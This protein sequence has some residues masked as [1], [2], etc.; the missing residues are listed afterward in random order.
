MNGCFGKYIDVDLS[1]EKVDDYPI[2]ESWYE[3]HLGGRGI[4]T[5]ILVEELEGG[6]DPLGPDNIMVFATGPYQGTGAPGGGKHAIFGRSPKNNTINESYAGGYFGHAL[7]RSG[8]D[9][10]VIR[11]AAKTPQCLVIQN[12]K[13][14]IVDADDLWG[15]DT[16]EVEEKIKA[17]YKNVSVSSIG[18]AGENLVQSACIINDRC[19]SLGRSGWGAVM[20]SKK[21]KAIAC[22]GN[23][24]KPVYDAESLKKDIRQY[25]KYIKSREDRTF[26]GETGTINHVKLYSDLGTLPTKNF[27][28]ACYDD[29]VKIADVGL[30]P[31][32]VRRGTC[33]GCPIACKRVV[34]TE[35]MGRPVMERYGGPEYE[36]SVAF[37]SLCLN[38][39]IHAVCLANQLCNQYGLDTI[40]TGC[41]IAFVM[42]A[43]DKGLLSEAQGAK[44]G[45]AERVI[46]LVDL[47]AKREGIG[48]SLAKGLAHF[49]KEIGGEAFAMHIKGQEVPMHEPRGKV[50][51]A[52]SYA[53]S[54]RGA[55][56]VDGMHDHLFVIPDTMPLWGVTEPVDVF[57]WERKPEVDKLAGDIMS[58]T[59]S[60]IGCLFLNLPLAHPEQFEY[61]RRILRDI[62][63]MDL[64]P[65]AVALIGERNVVIRKIMTAW[66]GYTRADDDLPARFK[67]PLPGGPA[68][69]RP[70]IHEEFHAAVDKWYRLRGYDAY[71]PT[72]EKLA[73]LGLKE[74]QGLIRRNR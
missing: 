29:A 18:I 62:T 50:G 48:D 32:L 30:A 51:L 21:L 65:K 64:D 46:E 22:A 63:G 26:F 37:G 61:D 2:P 17:R 6:E 52:I 8:F 74:L 33:A 3:R 55:N 47:I 58:F 44:W 38:N 24:D 19:S 4:A 1:R 35:F 34:K 16:G 60:M 42:E 12:G 71:G 69:G 49:A 45:D 41:M 31:I 59:D 68:A 28:E 54:P 43:T 57:T 5:R 10:I 36:T 40:S 11:G 70:I 15:L 23:I 39:N 27:Q 66:D 13:V 53:T 67:A 73:E 25:V 7:G 56:H 14:E 20:G 72:D 9:G